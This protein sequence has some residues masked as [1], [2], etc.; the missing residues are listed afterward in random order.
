MP[1]PIVYRGGGQDVITYTFTDLV[2]G[3]GKVYLYPAK[4][5][6]SGSEVTFLPATTTVQ[7]DPEYTRVNGTNTADTDFDYV[8]VKTIQL[9][10]KAVFMFYHEC[11]N[12]GVGHLG[13]SVITLRKWDG[14]TETDI[15]SV[16]SEAVLNALN[17]R[18]TLAVDVPRTTIKMGETLRINLFQYQQG[19]AGTTYDVYHD[20]SDSANEKEFTAILPVLT[21]SP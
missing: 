5:S 6:I 9:E 7:S 14:T 10:G 21:A 1:V 17:A 3:G 2:T 4:A 16:T 12:A 15:C 18:V 11:N 13:W 8:M 20:P 19:G